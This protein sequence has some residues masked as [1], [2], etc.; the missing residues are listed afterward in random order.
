MNDARSPGKRKSEREPAVKNLLECQL[1]AVSTSPSPTIQATIKSGL[2]VVILDRSGRLPVPEFGPVPDV[3]DIG[4]KPFHS[5]RGDLDTRAGLHQA[6]GVRPGLGDGH[7]AM[8][9]FFQH[10]RNSLKIA[11]NL[12]F[13]RLCQRV[14]HKR[15]HAKDCTFIP[16]IAR[17]FL[18]P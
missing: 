17:L 7:A 12:F 13:R 14:L 16:A 6:V 10:M 11:L 5:R 8:G 9:G 15:E 1:A 4:G 18:C 3:R 2:K